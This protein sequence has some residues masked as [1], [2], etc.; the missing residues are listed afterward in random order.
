MRVTHPNHVSDLLPKDSN[1]TERKRP[2]SDKEIM[3]TGTGVEIRTKST[4][5]SVIKQ[6]RPDDPFVSKKVLDSLNLG[7]IKFSQ[8]ERDTL[9][10]IMMKKAAEIKE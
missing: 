1:I 9:A 3:A 4:P 10:K 8:T 6:N 5:E 7:L 2:D